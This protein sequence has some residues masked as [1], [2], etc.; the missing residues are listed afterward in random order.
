MRDIDSA[1]TAFREAA[2]AKGDFQMPRLD[3]RLYR[4]MHQALRDLD[5]AGPAGLAAF[6]TLASDPSPQVR[7][8]VATELLTRGHLEMKPVI[9]EIARLPGLIG[10]S[11][12]TTLA[13]FDR[14]RL[15][16]PFSLSSS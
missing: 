10:F 15:Q 16:S 5:A 6:T 11:A 2:V 3:A 4:K 14:G 12:A 9:E 13:E 7:L 8:W 1:V